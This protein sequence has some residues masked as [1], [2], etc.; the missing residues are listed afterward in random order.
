[1]FVVADLPAGA[2]LDRAI[3]DQF[4]HWGRAAVKTLLNTRKVSVNGKLVWLGSW[5]VRNGDQ[6]AIS[7]APDARPAAPAEFDP[8]WLVAEDGGLIVVNKPAG[9]RSQ[10]SHKGDIEHLEALAAAQFGDVRLVHRLDRDTSGLV[11]FARPDKALNAYLDA[12]FKASEMHKEYL[13]VVAGELRVDQGT[14]HDY[15]DTDPTRSDKMTVVPKGGAL[16]LTDVQI[17]AGNAGQQLLRLF[18]RTGRTHQLRVQCA[19][20]GAPILGDRLYGDAASAPRLMLHAARL[21]L[22]EREGFPERPFPA[23]AFIAP[24]G[25]DFVDGLPEPFKT[26]I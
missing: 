13:A 16:A 22:P 15:L 11:L 21:A 5:K 19:S 9:L 2:R 14:L 26:E 17:L 25:S 7:A 20:R 8:A 3:R 10:A 4:P 1:V 12:A 6:I 23:R 18:P 24:P